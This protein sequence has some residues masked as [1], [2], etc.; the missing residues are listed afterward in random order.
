MSSTAPENCSETKILV[1]LWHSKSSKFWLSSFCDINKSL[2]R[3]FI[4]FIKQRSLTLKLQLRNKYIRLEDVYYL[5]RCK[6]CL[7]NVKVY[8]I[9]FKTYIFLNNTVC[10]KNVECSISI[11]AYTVFLNQTKHPVFNLVFKWT[12]YFVSFAICLYK[13]CTI[14]SKHLN[15]T[16][17]NYTGC[18]KKLWH[19]TLCEF[20]NNR[21][22][23]ILCCY[24]IQHLRTVSLTFEISD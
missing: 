3:F 24:R 9:T 10:H 5:I 8:K 14:C 16:H 17:L 21:T 22:V 15:T 11:T 18:H 13:Y 6:C 1:N 2:W 23:C 12:S 19:T 20:F 7:L 4:N